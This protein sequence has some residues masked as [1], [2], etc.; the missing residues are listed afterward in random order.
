MNPQLSGRVKTILTVISTIT[1]SR[2]YKHTL[3]ILGSPAR[4]I[5]SAMPLIDA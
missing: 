3:L 4:D 1:R 5:F 2:K